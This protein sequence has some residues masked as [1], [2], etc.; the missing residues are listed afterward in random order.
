[1]FSRTSGLVI[2]KRIA[3]ETFLETKNSANI[4]GADFG[5]IF[6]VVGMHTDQATDA[7]S[8]SLWWCS[9]TVCPWRKNTGINTEI[10]QTTDIRI[11]NDLEDQCTQ[12]SIVSAQAISNVIFRLAGF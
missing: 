11:G 2:T 12:R 8:F 7:F 9:V 5:D 3:G 6:A 1:M 10:S 4:P